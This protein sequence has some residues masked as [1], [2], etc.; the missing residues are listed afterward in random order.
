LPKVQFLGAV[1]PVSFRLTVP[2]QRITRIDNETGNTTTYKI[3][4]CLGIINVECESDFTDRKY[5]DV[6]YLR[7]SEMV[8]AAVNMVAFASGNGFHSSLDT[9]IQDDGIPL[10]IH[11]QDLTI[12]KYCSAFTFTPSGGNETEFQQFYKL[13]VTDPLME[14]TL[15]DLVSTLIDPRLSPISCGRAMDGIKNLIGAPGSS[16]S[17]SWEQMRNALNIDRRYLQY[18]TSYSTGPRHAKRDAISG[19]VIDEMRYRSWTVMNRYFEYRKR[20]T[21]LTAPEFPLLVV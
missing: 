19:A 4:I 7:A 15:N 20:N 8:R 3:N 16:D 17:A 5:I 11:S 12:S 2:G 13:V 10:P 18:I 14:F 6:L 9:I 21:P 1:I